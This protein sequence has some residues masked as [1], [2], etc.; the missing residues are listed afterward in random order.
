MGTFE[1]VENWILDDEFRLKCLSLAK[2]CMEHEWYLSAGFVRSLIWDKLHGYKEMTPL[3]DIDVIY[4]NRSCV[5]KEYDQQIEGALNS[6]MPTYNWSVK[7]QARMAVKHGHKPYTGCIEAMS[8]WPEIQTAVGATILV[9]D[10]ISVRS[11]FSANEVVRLAASKNVK[12]TA[13]V[14]QSR[15]TDKGWSKSWPKLEIET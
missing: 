11:P 4:F 14:F 10:K 1:L 8:Y 6:V 12:C 15:V 13:S 3:N 2:E 9:D 5:S 7:N